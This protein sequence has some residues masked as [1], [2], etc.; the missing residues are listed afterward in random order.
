MKNKYYQFASEKKQHKGSI[1][2]IF[3]MFQFREI[4]FLVIDI[5]V[6]DTNEIII[7]GEK[8]RL[9]FEYSLLLPQNVNVLKKRSFPSRTRNIHKEDLFL[10]V[11]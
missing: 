9:L 7:H 2:Y 5:F 1:R 8:F 10:V 3:S 4:N 11:F 6:R